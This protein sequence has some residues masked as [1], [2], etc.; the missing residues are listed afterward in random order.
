LVL[1]FLSPIN[2]LPITTTKKAIIQ[3]M[4]KKKDFGTMWIPIFFAQ[5]NSP[6]TEIRN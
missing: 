1:A 5:E 3:T 2:C 6:E 4:Q